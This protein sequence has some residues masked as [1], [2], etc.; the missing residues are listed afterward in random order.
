MKENR[1]IKYALIVLVIVVW[2]MILFQLYKH[3]FK[4][5][6]IVDGAKSIIKSNYIDLDTLDYKLEL[7]YPDPF[8]K[9]ASKPIR[10]QVSTKI[11]TPISRID[12]LWISQI[13]YLGVIISQQK[14]HLAIIKNSNKNEFK[15]IGDTINNYVVTE[16]N[17]NH[18]KIKRKEHE[19]LINKF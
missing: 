5:D 12:T 15:K 2:G 18:I 19:I 14:T 11:K 1:N 7:N 4:E 17:K 9:N 6:K 16:I 10:K 3:Y 13:K 8:L